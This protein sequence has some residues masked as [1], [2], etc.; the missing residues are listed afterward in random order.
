MQSV[1]VGMLTIFAVLAVLA[2]FL[3][4]CKSDSPS[5]PAA[6]SNTDIPADP[7]T[8]PPPPAPTTGDYVPSSLAI[9]PPAAGN[10]ARVRLTVGGV[11]AAGVSFST[12]NVT[13]VEDTV[14]KGIKL[15]QGAGAGLKADI[16]F[17]IDNTGSMSSGI[18]S[19]KNSI[20]TFVS[21]L[22]SSGQDV[23]V[24]AVAY[25]DDFDSDGDSVY[26]V[27][28]SDTSWQAAVYGYRPLTSNLDSTGTLFQFIATLPATG[29]GDSP[30]LCFSAMDF[31]RSTFAWRPGAQRIYIVITDITS[32]GAS[33]PSY[34]GIGPTYPWTDV[35]LGDQL[36]S[37]G[38]VVHCVSPDLDTFLS[39]GEYN[40]KPLATITGGTW[41][42]YTYAGFDLTTLPILNV[43]TSSVLV[44]FLK[45]G[46][47][48]TVRE[49]TLRVVIEVSPTERGERT[50]ITTY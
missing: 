32:W 5:G 49:R 23:Q 11:V 50:L 36:K 14:V 16:V 48:S 13:V 39:T 1:R 35:T 33:G 4:G 25:N 12:S 29:G 46:D 18:E 37:E 40:V 8:S 43:T 26:K 20:L 34:K 6:A 10:P 19:V 15:T 27:S 21:A 7:G 17:V 41:T 2:L 24:G 30:E 44:E 45:S 47:A 28:S 3:T 22:R 31:V 42:E 38:A 9:T